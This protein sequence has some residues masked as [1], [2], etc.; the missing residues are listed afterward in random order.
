MRKVIQIRLHQQDKTPAAF[1]KGYNEARFKIP[2][3]QF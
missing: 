1:P 2:G 3:I